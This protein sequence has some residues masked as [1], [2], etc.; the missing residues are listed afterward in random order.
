MPASYAS[1][2]ISSWIRV[3]RSAHGKVLRS[4]DETDL[5]SP[6]MFDP[7]RP[8]GRRRGNANI[9]YLQHLVL[10][11]EHGELQPESLPGLFPD[12]QMVIANSFRHTPDKPRF[13]AVFFTSQRMTLEVYK[14]IYGWIGDKLEEAGY[15]VNR[16]KRLQPPRSSNSPPSGLDWKGSSPHSIL[17]L[18][19]RTENRIYEFIASSPFEQTGEA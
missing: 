6:A 9:V 8:T 7:T 15:S 16:P 13:R 10:D 2:D 3:L 4:K 17:Y 12:L 14:L 1:G 11:F 5:F 18:P 19:C